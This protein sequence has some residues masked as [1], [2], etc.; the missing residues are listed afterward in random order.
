M[1]NNDG[2][3]A[4]MNFSNDN[5]INFW[6]VSSSRKDDSADSDD[7]VVDVML[8][9]VLDLC[10]VFKMGCRIW[11]CCCCCT[12]NDDDEVFTPPTQEED[13]GAKDWT[14][15]MT[16]IANSDSARDRD[17]FIIYIALKDLIYMCSFS[18]RCYESLTL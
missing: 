4:S 3:P 12:T 7:D 1:K 8:L 13:G 2:M 17:R 9:I 10:N 18:D 15:P 14:L 6:V 16:I 5:T 11:G